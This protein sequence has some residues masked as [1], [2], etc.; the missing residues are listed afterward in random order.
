MVSKGGTEGSA[1]TP[2]IAFAGVEITSG[3]SSAETA[4]GIDPRKKEALRHRM[5]NIDANADEHEKLRERIKTLEESLKRL[6]R[7]S[8][9]RAKLG[10]ERLAEKYES[11][12]KLQP[13]NGPV[14]PCDGLDQA[15]VAS[16]SVEIHGFYTGPGVLQIQQPQ[17][18]ARAFA[19]S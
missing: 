10:M 17:A 12:G 19:M 15:H 16:M 11:G 7:E 1:L 18:P 5:Q 4:H 3:I 2:S 13:P 6:G 9:D 14:G 8:L